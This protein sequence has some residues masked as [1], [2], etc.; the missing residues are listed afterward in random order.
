MTAR[1]RKKL[2]RNER[3]PCGSG[4]KV[5][6]CC[7]N[8]TIQLEVRSTSFAVQF[9]PHLAGAR[10]EARAAI[11]GEIHAAMQQCRNS[12]GWSDAARDADRL[13]HQLTVVHE[14]FRAQVEQSGHDRQHWYIIVRS[15]ARELLPLLEPARIV[16]SHE[17][18]PYLLQS[19][20]ELVFD[21][22]PSETP[23]E[24]IEDGDAEGMSYAPSPELVVMAARLAAL[25]YL[26]ANVESGYRR[27]AKGMSIAALEGLRSTEEQAIVVS[28]NDFERRKQRYLTMTGDAGFWY[29]AGAFSPRIPDLV[30][31][32]SAV[33]AKPGHLLSVESV[34][35]PDKRSGPYFPVLLLESRWLT[36]VDFSLHPSLLPRDPWERGTCLASIPFDALF[37]RFSVPIEKAL[38]IGTPRLTSFLYALGSFI[39]VCIGFNV[40][41]TDREIP[42]FE[43]PVSTS[44][45][46][47]RARLDHFGDVLELGLL[48]SSRV[49]WLEGLT[50]A[51][52]HV[53]TQHPDVLRLSRDDLAEVIDRFTFRGPAS[54][55]KKGDPY[56]FWAPSSKTLL[57]DF[58]GMNR[59]L[60]DVLTSTQPSETQ[61]DGSLERRG[62][63]FEAQARSFFARELQLKPNKIAA[64]VKAGRTQIDLAFV[65]KRTLFVLECKAQLKDAEDLA[66]VHR[67]VRNRLTKFREEELLKNLPKRIE[68]VRAGLVANT[69]APS[70]FEAAFGLVCTSTVEYLPKTSVE[71]WSGELPLVGPPEELLATI[72][73]LA[74]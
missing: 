37:E 70:D 15:I 18:L 51:T 5:K 12:S 7:V 69:I 27:V 64:D 49:Q 59:F 26:H 20:N 71:L 23:V 4:K 47:R 67:K 1:R 61:S 58:F 35:P 17:Y 10:E 25:A 56:L 2:G 13:E 48:R 24:W 16:P 3:C 72:V 28:V 52:N 50:E 60:H 66:G 53:S 43:W 73:A 33:S 14:R 11:T 36:S 68:A 32:W 38:K 6:H 41:D 57:F 63:F 74:G 46:W 40:L 39:S 22:D 9:A 42:R 8:A 31:L 55:R 44:T 62:E 29:D 30:R 54:R 19:L 21:C 34:K 65:W 45:R